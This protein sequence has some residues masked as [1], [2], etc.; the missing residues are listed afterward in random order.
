M[1]LSH[2]IT[3][4]LTLLLTLL[5]GTVRAAWTEMKLDSP[6]SPVMNKIVLSD[7]EWRWLGEKRQLRVAIWQPSNPPFEI[8]TSRQHYAGINADFLASLTESLGVRTRV[9]HYPSRE[10]ALESV[11]DGDA[12]L[13][14]DDAGMSLPEASRLTGTRSF[15]DNTPVLVGRESTSIFPVAKNRALRLA[16]ARGYLSDAVVNASYPQAKIVRYEDHQRAIAAVATGKADLM[17]SNLISA[18]FLI[19]RN[20]VKDLAVVGMLPPVGNG[21]RFIVREDNLQLLNALNTAIAAVPESETNHITD[22]WSQGG[23][24]QYLTSPLPLTPQEQ[25]WL[26]AHP[27][28][29]VLLN[30]FFAPLSVVDDNGQFHGI[31]A[32][33]LRLIHLRTGL[34]FSTETEESVDQM[35]QRVVKGEGDMLAAIS[36]SPTRE[37]QLAFTSSYLSTPF[38]L[39]TRNNKTGPTELRDGMTL[40]AL[41]GNVVNDEIGRQYPNI[42]W[43]PVDNVGIALQ[44]VAAGEADATLTT[45]IAANYLIDRYYLGKLKVTAHVGQQP[46]R[47]GFAVR[48]DAPELESILNKALAGIPPSYITGVINKWQGTPIARQDTWQIYGAQF[49]WLIALAGLLILCT[50]VWGISLRRTIRVRQQAESALQGQ[51][52]LRDI[53]LNGSPTPVYVVGLQGEIITHNHAFDRFFSGQDAQALTLPLFDRRHPLSP[54]IGDLTMLMAAPAGEPLSEQRQTYTLDAPDGPRIIVHWATPWVGAERRLI[55]GWQDIT[56]QQQLLAEV[57]QE[58]ENAQAASKAKSSFLAHM[59]HEVRTPISAVIGLLEL[60]N[61][62]PQRSAADDEPLRLAHGAAQ[63]LLGIIGDILDMAKIESGQLDLV[64]EWMDVRHLA[65]ETLQTFAGQA[66][67][68]GLTLH[69]S[70]SGIDQEIWLD[71][72]RLRQ[73]LANLIGNAVKFTRVGAISLQ[74][75]GQPQADGTLQL[76]VNVADSGIGMSSEEQATL[77]RPFSQ[78]EAGRRQTGTGL[79]LTISKELVEKMGGELTLHSAPGEGTTFTLQLNVPARLREARSPAAT[80][81]AGV[82]ADA[83]DRPLRLLIADDHPTNRLLLR[84]QLETLGHQVKEA[85]DGIRALQLWRPGR[86]DLLITDCNMPGMDGYQLTAAIRRIDATALIWGL[87]AN[88]QPEARARCLAAGMDRCLFKPLTLAG[89]AQLLTDIPQVGVADRP[90]PAA[91][92]PERP[93]LRETADAAPPTIPI[94]NPLP[95]TTSP[96]AEPASLPP[97]AANAGGPAEQ[98][99]LAEPATT[100]V[101]PPALATLI[102]LDALQQLTGSQ[103]AILRLMLEKSREENQKDAAM[104]A[105]LLQQQAWPQLASCLHRIGGAASILGAARIEALCDTLEEQ[106]L[107][108][109]QTLNESALDGLRLQLVQLDRAIEQWLIEQN[110]GH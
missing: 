66:Q 51:L 109:P 47:I 49:Y 82:A 97:V 71:A 4:L 17:V 32:D 19:E 11:A 99:A 56:E 10:A 102:D 37:S 68:K 6:A 85:E 75:N 8:Y 35:F 54:L 79:G 70:T 9:Q 40:A 110:T 52:A 28:I 3:L 48:K 55:C 42:R 44:K 87:T 77:F 20:Y 50:L 59:S 16:A 60:V 33:I 15:M 65:E 69:F 89:L 74:L 84:H 31:S 27:Q 61:S 30:P 2:R 81:P 45:L 7:A 12:D 22:R 24:R 94:D 14:V 53:L 26:A 98:N 58:K 46:A 23:E 80:L 64:P 106:C 96:A 38:V 34:N 78:L 83:H 95:G 21:S 36:T 39:V 103:T 41:S 101:S 1:R 93:A 104:A 107:H 63:S 13:L 57:S 90:L 67:R 18:N 73:V 100:D 5:T 72:I 62:R 76:I 105:Q 25:R 29:H 86:F 91:Q 43:L 88:A 92:Q 108:A